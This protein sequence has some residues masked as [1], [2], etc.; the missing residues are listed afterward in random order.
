MGKCLGKAPW[1]G[2]WVGWKGGLWGLLALEGFI[3][4]KYLP[5]L[6]GSPVLGGV[7]EG[8]FGCSS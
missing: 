2:F 4:D 6:A 8:F 1:G 3:L 5:L 7:L